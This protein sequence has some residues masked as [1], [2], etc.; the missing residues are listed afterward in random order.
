MIDAVSSQR[1]ANIAARL[2]SD[3]DG[4]VL[5]AA[6]L[7][8]R[9]LADH[10]MTITD[11][12]ESRG[13][14]EVRGRYPAPSPTRDGDGAG[15]PPHVPKID[16]LLNPRWGMLRSHRTEKL[17]SSMRLTATIT[18][19]EQRWLD[20]LH[21]RMVRLRSKAVSNAWVNMPQDYAP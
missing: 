19:D 4:E 3:H 13:P 20:A 14:S 10:G 5:N 15:L 9:G 17:L 1:L 11:L 21:A 7:L 2:A 6:R 8:V 18:A 16:E 12:F